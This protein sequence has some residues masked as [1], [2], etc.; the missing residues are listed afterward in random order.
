M[1]DD[2]YLIDC[3]IVSDKIA[4]EKFVVDTGAKFTCCNYCVIDGTL[5]ESQFSGSEVKYIGGFVRGEI[6]KFYRY[7]LKQFTVGNIDMEKQCIWLT[8]DERVTDIDDYNNSF[9]LRTN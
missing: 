4:I 1:R 6:V 2:R 8:F 3:V 9:E 7:P 5:E